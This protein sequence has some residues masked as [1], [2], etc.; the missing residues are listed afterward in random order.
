MPKPV[1]KQAT[2]QVSH[3]KTLAKLSSKITLEKLCDNFQI[4]AGETRAIPF[5]L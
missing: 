1:P 3:V 2:V 5:H 4:N